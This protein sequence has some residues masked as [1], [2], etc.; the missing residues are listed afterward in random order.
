MTFDQNAGRWLALTTLLLVL[1]IIYFLFFHWFFVEHATLN[2]EIDSLN[3]SRQKFINESAKTPLLR[4]KIKLPA[5]PSASRPP[6]IVTRNSLKKLFFG[7]ECAVSL[8][9][10]CTSYSKLRSIS[11]VYLLMI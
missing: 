5:N 2:E 4:E 7:L 9:S 8:M 3:D 6:R 11:P 10:L 1:V